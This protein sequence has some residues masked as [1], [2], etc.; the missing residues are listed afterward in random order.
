M[1]YEENDKQQGG[2]ATALLCAIRHFKVW[3]YF[4]V[5]NDTCPHAF[6]ERA[7]DGDKVCG[8]ADL[9]QNFPESSSV[10]RIECLREANKDSNSSRCCCLA[11]NIIY[12]VLRHARKPH[13]LSG[14]IGLPMSSTC[15]DNRLRITRPSILPGIDSKKIPRWSSHTER[16][17][18][19]LK[20][21]TISAS[22]NSCGTDH[23]FQMF[24]KRW[25]RL[26]IRF[27]PPALN[28]CAGRLSIPGALPDAIRF[29]ALRTSSTH[30][31]A[32]ARTHTLYCLTFYDNFGKCRPIF[33]PKFKSRSQNVRHWHRC[34][35][36]QK[37]LSTRRL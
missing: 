7:D 11:V 36:A 29:T 17:P 22:L 10:Y 12:M 15:L 13:W 9:Q 37:L 1:V 18:F 8:A 30:T 2:K 31:R 3:R 21:C 35:V 4:T 19:R 26:V 23:L 5:L 20:M 16:S 14:N 28:T 33:R 25:V 6:M 32:H 24:W 27:R 34:K